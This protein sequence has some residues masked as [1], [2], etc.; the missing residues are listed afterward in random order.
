MDPRV[1]P[2]LGFVWFVKK[3]MEG[4]EFTKTDE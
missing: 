1:S 3:K 2:L 4:K